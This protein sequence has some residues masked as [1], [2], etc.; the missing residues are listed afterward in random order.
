MS[1]KPRNNA[2]YDAATAVRS[3]AELPSLFNDIPRTQWASLAADLASPLQAH[4]LAALSSYG[5]K[6]NLQEIAEVYLPLSRLLNQYAISAAEMH[7]RTRNFLQHKNAPKS[8]FVIGIAGSVAVGKS[9]VARV[10]RELLSRWSET[11]RVALVTTDGFLYSN[12]QLKRR[13]L[14]DRKGFPES[15]DRRSLLRFVARVKA[16]MPEVKAPVYSHLVYDVV[17]DKFTLVNRPDIL[18]I[19]GINVLQPPSSKKNPLALSDLFDFSI[20]VD[21]RTKD[22]KTWYLKRFLRLRAS[23]FQDPQSFFRPLAQISEADAI[24][25]AKYY[26]NT[27]NAPNLE[28]NIKPTRGRASLILRKDTDHSVQKILLRKL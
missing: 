13:G 8:P 10:L 20:Y 17:P 11:P 21:A 15:Y 16:G 23:A 22:I 18:I 3:N 9:T 19:E 28:Q 5:E 24:T 1:E 27:I 4:E 6:L 14:L 26:W 12:A 7:R 25:T 2:T